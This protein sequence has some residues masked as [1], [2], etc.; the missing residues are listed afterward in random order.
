MLV[1]FGAVEAINHHP[2]VTGSWLGLLA[3]SALAAVALTTWLYLPGSVDW[4]PPGPPSTATCSP[5]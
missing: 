3:Y 2:H 4:D 1:P 5:S